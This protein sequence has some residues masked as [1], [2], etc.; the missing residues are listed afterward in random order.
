MNER[1]LILDLTPEMLAGQLQAWGEPAYR[2]R[3]IE[4]WVYQRYVADFAAM[5]NLPASLRSR[6]AET[7]I[8]SP[9]HEAHAVTSRDRLTHKVLFALNDGQTIEAVLMLYDRR[10]TL[11]I[12]TQVGC[13]MGCPFCATGL[14]GLARNLTAGEIVAQVLY[15]ARLLS[16]SA[17]ATSPDLAVARPT[18][19]TNIVVMGMGEPL[20]NYAATWQA[21][22]D[23]TAPGRFGLSAR[24]ITLSTVG[25]APMIDRMAEEPLPIG[26]AVS[27]HAPTDALRDQLVPINRRYSLAELLAACRRY[28]ARTRR[29][30]TFEYALMRDL[31]DSPD[32][33][34]AL[35][36]LL[37]GL[38]CHVNLIPLNPVAGSPYQPSSPER[39]AAF[40]TVLQRHGI[41]ATIRLRRGIEINA[42]CGQLRRASEGENARRG[43]DMRAGEREKRRAG[44]RA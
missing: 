31:N 10:R 34:E 30:V 24:A 26:L 14:G 25:L 32:H 12:S 13:G 43:E 33:A 11:C 3:Q 9:L 20:A 23:L 44:E 8:L 28:I 37:R 38:L 22:R 16:A 4:E 42:G 40:L 7:Y 18:H 21:L 19:V 6:L 5:T 1:T 36:Q 15:F 39:A 27:L 2:A 41:P 17:D 29:R 35:A